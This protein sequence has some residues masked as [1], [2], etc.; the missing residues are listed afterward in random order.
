MDFPS[1]LA[2]ESIPPEVKRV[3]DIL[4]T[5]GRTALIV[6]GAVR[7]AFIGRNIRDWDVS[8]DAPM[9]AVLN[10]FRKVIPTGAAHGTVTVVMGKQHIEV[11]SFQ[12]ITIQEDL[13]RRDFTINA[14]AWDPSEAGILDP[15][16]GRI[17]A[18]KKCLRAV[19]NPSDRFNEDPLRTIRA[20][21]IASELGFHIRK[22]TLSAI[23]EAAKQLENVS[24]ERI[25][26]EL[27]RIL[28]TDE[29]SRAFRNMRK[30]GV[31][32]AVL[33]ELTEGHRKRQRKD[34]HR[35]TVLEH[36][37][38]IIDE[39]PENLT[40][41]WAGLLHDIGK[42][43]T[44]RFDGEKPT[45]HNHETVSAKMAEAILKRLCF[46]KNDERAVVRLVLN[47]EFFYSP[48][49]SDAAVRRWIHRT[50]P[51]R[52]TEQIALRR[53]DR[54]ATGMNPEDLPFL[55]ELEARAKEI[56]EK[57]QNKAEPFK[58]VINGNDVKQ[59]LSL[60]AGPKIG[61]I[62]ARMLDRVLEA[63]ESN[64]KEALTQWLKT[65]KIEE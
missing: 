42:P 34:K 18:E 39:L 12:G 11:T 55:D 61:K 64:S 49:W 1:A 20:F 58:P 24:N 26:E 60:K 19:G 63:P 65:L 10:T 8:T 13:A 47:H 45:F 32:S 40:L 33:Q 37:F 46:S 3:L 28:L 15:W 38:H 29:P 41:R 4:K 5:K 50:G 51:D 9:E 27:N 43:R 44:R 30:T 57:E 7:D 23:P 22:D 52:I 17:D 53:A 25:R 62:M 6:G 59:I 36:A 35:Y 31:L 2:P 16:N 54:I 56:L 48:D 14:M 21:R